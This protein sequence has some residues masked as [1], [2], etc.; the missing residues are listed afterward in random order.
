MGYRLPSR[1]LGVS[2]AFILDTICGKGNGGCPTLFWS[3]ATKVDCVIGNVEMIQ[4]CGL[5][6][7]D[8][9]LF[10]CL[11]GCGKAFGSGGRLVT[12]SASKSVFSR[13]ESWVAIWSVMFLE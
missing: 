8:L 3:E 10:E 12:Q 6:E 5:L 9:V 2:R 7:V 4:A 11:T 13:S 1:V